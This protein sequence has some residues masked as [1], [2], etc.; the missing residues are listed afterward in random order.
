M[1]SARKNGLLLAALTLLAS[2]FLLCVYTGN[3]SAAVDYF[4]AYEKMNRR[5]PDDDY[6]LYKNGTAVTSSG[7][8]RVKWGC[9]TGN[10]SYFNNKDDASSHQ[11]ITLGNRSINDDASVPAAAAYQYANSTEIVVYSW[12]KPTNPRTLRISAVDRGIGPDLA[13]KNTLSAFYYSG[14][15]EIPS[16]ESEINFSDC[17]GRNFPMGIPAEAFDELKSNGNGTNIYRAKVVLRYG[18]VDGTD[19]NIANSQISFH[20]SVDEGRVGYYGASNS[21]LPKSK[22]AEHGWVNSYPTNFAKQNNMR[23]YFRPSCSTAKGTPFTIEWDDVNYNNSSI[24]QTN[25]AAVLYKY[26]PGNIGSR[27]AVAI[28]DNLGSGYQVRTEN[29]DSYS[30]GKQ[31]YA[32]M[33]EFR[34]ISGGNGISF[35]HPFNSAD[36]RIECPPTTPPPATSE[37][38]RFTYTDPGQAVPAGGSVTRDTNTRV[39]IKDSRERILVDG[40]V[41]YTGPSTGG[42][43]GEGESGQWSYTPT[44]ER[45]T[46]EV[47]RR[48]KVLNSNNFIAQA[49][50]VYSQTFTCYKPTC[51]LNL[52]GDGPGGIVVA[53]GTVHVSA[54][55]SNPT[56]AGSGS[57]DIIDIPE[58]VA[59]RNLSITSDGVERRPGSTVYLGDDSNVVSWDLPALGGIGNQTVSAYPDFYGIG[60]IGPACP[61]T[62]PV[63]EYFNIDPSVNMSGTNWENPTTVTYETCGNKTQGPDVKATASSSLSRNGGGVSSG[64]ATE[65]YGLNVCNTYTYNPP[66]ITAGDRYCPSVTI[67]FAKGYKGPGGEGD[68]VGGEPVTVPGTC[69][70]VHNKPYVHFFGSDVFAGG[71]FGASCTSKVAGIETYLNT[72]TANGGGQPSGSGVQIGALS[73]GA[74]R[75]FNSALLRSVEPSG[76]N[77]LMFSNTN[78]ASPGA[79]PGAPTVGGN[80]GGDHCV[81]DYFSKLPAGT[82]SKNGPT[83]AVPSSNG[84]DVQY[85]DHNVRT[86]PGSKVKNGLQ[87]VVYVKGDVL[88]TGDG[89][90]F[91]NTTW[92]SIEDIPSFYMIVKGDIYI[93]SSV[94]QLDGIYVAQ[95]DGGNGGRIY[96]CTNGMSLFEAKDLLGNCRSQLVVNGAFVADHIHF[97]RSFGSLR[98]SSVGERFG[99]GAKN[100][101]DSGNTAF[102]DC[103]AEIFNYSPELYLGSTGLPA[104]TGPTTGKYDFITSLSPVL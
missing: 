45:V 41:N 88:I 54:Y 2:L 76:T 48:Y 84:Q 23:F 80:L 40:S 16:G 101:T 82:V 51:N 17:N 71:G 4:D 42:Y 30:G 96:T 1:I 39:V 74:A 38:N 11:Y 90:R 12:G 33:I 75:G 15:N 43:L 94:T 100:C 61:A 86:T 66:S 73:I 70:N 50:T 52:T 3:A 89:V 27:Q 87:A 57:P 25:P 28:Y 79:G 49:D 99:L 18:N 36:A 92:S 95:P 47:T 64:S 19:N 98:N 14:D 32:Y 104:T 5:L 97:D 10:Y 26:R 59:G 44:G 13:C 67:T 22:G 31:P 53:G 8:C 60:S 37:C 78:P 7:D 34:D 83:Y 68:I 20:V 6:T 35:R 9:T 65:T 56:R 62:V 103:A 69:E 77:G 93:A 81:P 58:N 63:Y 29:T 72:T 46:I 55:I 21:K 24:Q 91:Q 85:Y 102:G